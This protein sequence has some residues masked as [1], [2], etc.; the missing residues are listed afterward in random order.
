M[1]EPPAGQHG[2]VLASPPRPSRRLVFAALGLALTVAVVAVGV[3]IATRKPPPRG[4]VATL[5]GP[6]GQ[7]VCSAAF[8]PGGTTLAVAGCN[9][10][11]FLWDVATR[12]WIA[13]LTGSG[14]PQGGQIAFSPDGKTLALFGGRPVS[15]SLTGKHPTTCLWDVR[16]QR[17]IALADPGLLAFG[18]TNGA[19]SPDGTTLAV[20]DNSGN[21]YLW[22]VAARRVTATVPASSYCAPTCTVAF[23]LDGTM[24]AVGESEPSGDHG[25]VYLWNL[26]AKRWAGMLTSP[27]R[28]PVD[29][30]AFSREGILAA[31]ADD[32][33]YLWNVATR[34]LTG[35][36][37]PPINAAQGNAS[38]SKGGADGGPYPAPGAFARAVTA[39]FSP[40]GTI[41][42]VDASFGYGTYLYDLATRKRIAALTYA[43]G[44]FHF[45]APIAFSPDGTMLA[46]GES[47]ATSDHGHVYLWDMTSSR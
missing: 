32:H 6:G 18:S 38:I 45:A 42:A 2:G 28:G 7:A 34:R 31:G 20:A 43:G 26:A 22:N 8:R 14:C 36:I 25:H 47:E 23:S 9:D 33:T 29:S 19:F 4:L 24:L 10:G 30:L 1:R 39:A 35:T 46:V 5:S 41:L 15:A 3:I 27:G 37:A 16:A 12:R 40:D 17:E 21:I 13:T 11:V 44:R